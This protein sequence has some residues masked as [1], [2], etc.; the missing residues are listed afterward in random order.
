MLGTSQAKGEKK[1]QAAPL[2]TQPR[3]TIGQF[4]FPNGKP[5]SKEEKQLGE[6]SI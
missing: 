3:D 4:Y 1:K 5:I 6:T 2:I